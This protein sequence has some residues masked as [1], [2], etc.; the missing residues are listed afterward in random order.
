MIIGVL[1]GM[2]PAAT[3]DLFAKII[4]STSVHHDQDHLRIIVDNNPRIPDRQR[5]IV[6]GGLSPLPMLVE[7]ARNLQAA[8][9][10]FIVIPCSTAHYWIDEL[11]ASIG[12]PVVDMIEQTAKRTAALYPTLRRVGIMAATGTVRAR[13]YQKHFQTVKIETSLPSD[14]DQVTLMQLI[15]AVKAGELTGPR[16]T[17]IEIGERLVRAGAEAVVAGCTEIPLVLNMNDLSVP[18]VDATQIL[19]TRVVEIAQGLVPI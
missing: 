9:A 8:G 18:L 19:A 15:Y 10:D 1:G 11:R 14:E 5:A 12:I 13:L 2:G 4:R 6:D 3:V 7:T 17:A 16:V